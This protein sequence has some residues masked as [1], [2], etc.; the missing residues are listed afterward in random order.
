MNYDEIRNSIENMAKENYQDFIKAIIS[1]EK[2]IND[3]EALDTLYSQFMENDTVNLL[4]EE[5]DYMI[6]ELREQGQIKDIPYQPD[7]DDIVTLVGNVVGKV[8]AIER[9]N[10][11]GGKFSVVNFS[12]L[13]KDENGEKKY[14]NCSAYGEKGKLAKDFQRGDFV[15]IS[16]QL[17]SSIDDNGKEHTNLRVLSTKMLKAREQMQNSEK[18]KEA[19]K[20]EIQ[21]LQ[22]QIEDRQLDLHYADSFEQ[23]GQIREDIQKMEAKLSSLEERIKKTV[24]KAS[25]KENKPKDSILGA[26]KKL[27][28]ESTEKQEQ[29]PI[30]GEMEL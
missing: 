8:E 12:L 25:E 6:D 26:I 17:R 13:T 9:E 24:E 7:K 15:K 16:G 29:K 10:K 22:E 21:S 1:Y 23:S 27:K 14:H 11:N 28:E 3:K 5:F 18:E 2:G 30:K 19:L 20:K 4:H